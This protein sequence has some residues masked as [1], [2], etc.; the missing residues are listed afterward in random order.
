MLPPIEQISYDDGSGGYHRPCSATAALTSALYR[1]GC[2]VAVRVTGSTSIAR[3]SSVDNT[4]PPS[5]AVAPPD[6][7]EPAPRGTTGT[8]WVLAQRMTSRTSS[9]VRA[10]TTASGMPGWGALAQSWR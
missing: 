9:V 5:T 10:R 4:I 8:P 7:P 3:I 2:T 1:P 6:R